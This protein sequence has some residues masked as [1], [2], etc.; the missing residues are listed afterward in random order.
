VVIIGVG[1]VM[2]DIAHYMITEVKVE[3]VTAIA[4]RGPSEIRFDK[5]EL[6]AVAN[7][8][9]LDDLRA[10]IERLRPDLADLTE[11]IEKPLDLIQNALPKAVKNESKT[12]FTFRFLL[13][14]SRI[15]GNESGEVVG[16][17]VEENQLIK[18]GRCIKARGTGQKKILNA[19]T[20]IFAIGDR[21]DE[22]FGLSVNRGEFVKNLEPRFPMDGLSYEAFDSIKSKPVEGVF[23]AGWARRASSGLVGNTRK[24]GI[25]G[26]KAV[27][28]YLGTLPDKHSVSYEKILSF[29]S[30]NGKKVVTKDDLKKLKEIEVEMA[31]KMGLPDF[32]FG[33]N[34]EM[35]SYIV[36]PLTV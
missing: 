20:V 24:D 3:D 21:V 4:R 17:E 1:N 31:Q 28:N 33:S 25:N 14:P 6:D 26:A 10:E 7:N 13:S 35:L 23:L 27:L 2:M 15:I 8:V 29:L 11:N 12:R 30:K 32:K 18:F 16:V 9:D 34:D 5:A 36:Q 22:K 19:D